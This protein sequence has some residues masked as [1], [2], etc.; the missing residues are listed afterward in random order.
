MNG[1]SPAPKDPKRDDKAEQPADPL[2]DLTR[3]LADG[4][5]FDGAVLNGGPFDVSQEMA[6]P[7]NWRSSLT[8]LGEGG[9]IYSDH[10]GGGLLDEESTDSA[11]VDQRTAPPIDFKLAR[12]FV[13]GKLNDDDADR[14]ETLCDRYLA[15]EFAVG[16]ALLELENKTGKVAPVDFEQARKYVRVELPVEDAR[17]IRRAC[18][19]YDSWRNAVAAAAVELA[20]L[21]E[22]GRN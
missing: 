1:P 19:Q 11:P 18:D 14:V 2:R 3:A 6:R 13:R 5:L 12:R 10:S 9:P 17:A 16:A 22:Q 20:C 7:I 8:G 4:S 21:G 15:W